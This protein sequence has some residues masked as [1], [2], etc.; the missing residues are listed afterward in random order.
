M[1]L[2][3]SQPDNKNLKKKAKHDFLIFQ[4]FPEADLVGGSGASSLAGS[5]T[6]SDK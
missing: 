5:A 3:N 4:L 6:A 1:I 2:L